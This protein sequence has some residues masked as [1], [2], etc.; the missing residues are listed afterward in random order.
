MKIQT[1]QISTLTQSSEA[2]SDSKKATS[3]FA[4][5]L[6]KE[7]GGS[8]TDESGLTAP[9]LTGYAAL[10]LTDSQNTE[11]TAATDTATASASSTTTSTSD[12]A[13]MDTMDSL[14]T[15]WENYADELA[16][17][18]G[19]ASLKKAYG[20]LENIGTGV[21]QLKD[22]L[23]GSSSPGLDAMANELEVMT[24]TEKIKFDRGDYV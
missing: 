18:S 6:A 22:G 13:A 8:S 21:Q 1:D 10:D 5:V 19:G 23:A 9:V 16:S 24:V 11:T 3:D 17:G 20:L 4:S 15:Q 7:V 2:T 14:L 12:T